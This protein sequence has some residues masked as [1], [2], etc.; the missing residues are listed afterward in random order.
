[1]LYPRK[2]KCDQWQN[3]YQL[4]HP[5]LIWRINLADPQFR[6]FVLDLFN[7]FLKVA[8]SYFIQLF[9][10][11]QISELLFRRVN[12]DNIGKSFAIV[13]LWNILW[14][15]N[16]LQ[17]HM[18]YNWRHATCVANSCEKPGIL[19]STNERFRRLHNHTWYLSFFLHKHNFCLNFS[20]RKNA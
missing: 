2:G 1:M 14:L 16:N 13:N 3:S 7:M 6:P 17:I 9:S 20:P 10:Q 8:Y 15:D 18:I 12:K 11:I 4:Q 5:H 19:K